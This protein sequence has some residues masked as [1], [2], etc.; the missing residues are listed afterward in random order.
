VTA[1]DLRVSPDTVLLALAVRPGRTAHQIAAQLGLNVTY[2]TRRLIYDHP[3]RA[4]LA[5]LEQEGRVRHEDVPG[6]RGRLGFHRLW[7]PLSDRCRGAG[8]TRLEAVGRWVL[9]RRGAA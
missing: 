1:P 3:V 5:R 9:A 6:G 2:G 8:D 7:Y 4:Q